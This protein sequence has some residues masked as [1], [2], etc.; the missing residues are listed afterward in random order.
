MGIKSIL[1]NSVVVIG[2]LIS[3]FILDNDG[4][5]ASGDPAAL[6]EITERDR[7][8]LTVRALSDAINDP[9]SFNLNVVTSAISMENP[10]ASLDKIRHFSD[11]KG[12]L[13]AQLGYSVRQ[14]VRLDIAKINESD[15]AFSVSLDICFLANNAADR[16]SLTIEMKKS[17]FAPVLDNASEMLDEFNTF[18]DHSRLKAAP[19]IVKNDEIYAKAYMTQSAPKSNNLLRP[20]MFYDDGNYSIPRSHPIQI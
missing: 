15:S 4:L 5:W 17:G 8:V 3:F 19:V 9:N 10:A 12:S 16:K 20:K 6:A 13:A 11:T 14:E 1:S 7:V 18:I 2:L